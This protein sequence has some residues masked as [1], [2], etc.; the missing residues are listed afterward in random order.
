MKPLRNSHAVM[1]E[2]MIIILFFSLSSVVVVRLFAAAHQL[3]RQSTASTRLL[4]TAQSW[5]DQ[6]R[7]EDDFQAFLAENGWKNNEDGL[8][9]AV[10]GGIVKVT[11]LHEEE[12]SNGRLS[13]CDI[14]AFMEEQEVFSLPIANYQPEGK[15]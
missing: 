2:L 3:N 4:L 12:G 5:A 7:G 14:A 15:P 9:L 1:V 10:E 6:L 11:N 13:S 8:S